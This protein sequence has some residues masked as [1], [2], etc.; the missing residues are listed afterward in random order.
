VET[1]GIAAKSDRTVAGSGAM[2]AGREARSVMP[3]GHD[4]RAH[5]GLKRCASRRLPMRQSIRRARPTTRKRTTSTRAVSPIHCSRRSIIASSRVGASVRTA[6]L[7]PAASLCPLAGR[8]AD[9]QRRTGENAGDAGG[10]TCIVGIR[11]HSRH[12]VGPADFAAARTR[13]KSK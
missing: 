3:T 13:Q 1:R 5:A 11:G 8:R 2:S 9:L 4:P 12:R 7:V 6:A 10:R